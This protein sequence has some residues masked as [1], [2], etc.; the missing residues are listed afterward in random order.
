MSVETIF[1]LI[2]NVSVADSAING[3]ENISVSG[4]IEDIYG[5]RHNDGIDAIYTFGE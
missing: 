2:S 1:P 5:I 4:T 3:D